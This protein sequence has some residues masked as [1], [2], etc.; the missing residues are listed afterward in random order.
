M[1]TTKFMKILSNVR[2]DKISYFLI[3]RFKMPK[4]IAKIHETDKGYMNKK[5]SLERVVDTDVHI[6]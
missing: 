2:N 1:V 4:K 5:F 6:I 3:I